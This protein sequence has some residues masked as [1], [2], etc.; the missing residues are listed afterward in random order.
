MKIKHQSVSKQILLIILDGWGSN[1]KYHSN[2]IKQ[3]KTPVFDLLWHHH[4]KT[5]LHASSKHVG[6][7][8][9]QVGNSEVGHTT[10]GA[11]RI[12]NQELVR[13][14]KSIKNGE[15]SNNQTL[16]N[17][18]KT[19]QEN[20]KKIH[21]IGLCSNG[22]VHSHIE[23]L[24]ALIKI[25]KTHQDLLTCIH[26]ITD[27][28]DTKPQSAQ[29]FIHQIESNI[30]N[31]SNIRICTISGRYYSMDR[32]CRWQ[33]TEEAY[34]CLTKDGTKYKNSS[35]VITDH[36]KKNI[37]DEFITPSRIS[38]GHIEEGDGIIFFNFR[39][40]RM[41]QL[42]QALCNQ[43]FECFKTK[44]FKHLNIITFVTYDIKLNLPVVF[45]KVHKNNFLGQI[46]SNQGL[47]Q[48]RLAETEKYAHVTYFFNGG[49]EDPFPGEY[50]ELIA[51]PSVEKYDSTPEMSAKQITSKL[52]EI[53][54]HNLYQFIV[55]NYSNPDMIG[56]T[57]NF[58]A[59]K[60]AIETVDECLGQLVQKTDYNKTTIIIT[61]DHGNADIMLDNSDKP[62]KS[63]TSNQVPFIIIKQDNHLINTSKSEKIKLKSRGSLADIAP[64]IL[65][66]LSIQQPAEM[67]GQSL[68][69]KKKSIK[70]H[71][72]SL[73]KFI[74]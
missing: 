39:P 25:S 22:G 45:N 1:S 20:K 51:S 67:N 28:R 61:A 27:G 33:R 44:Q 19:T 56:H 3:A 8:T 41:R 24:I 55:V 32:D 64:T 47:K 30:S 35:Q 69:D 63:H 52:I 65:D 48:L 7:P 34:N 36:Y 58:Q 73:F 18:Y 46:I 21:L 9:G 4:P 42:T 13:I 57:G 50:R 40:D 49:R 10:M 12:I 54:G 2:A 5:L 70:E 43:S 16:K 71:I 14:S 59:T 26:I 38:Q 66:L 74:D 31:A 23:H 15:F 62:C 37:Y 17:I 6:L 60:Q 72:S 53:S 68:I 11:G 29:H